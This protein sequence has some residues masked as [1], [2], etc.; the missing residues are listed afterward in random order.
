MCH[1]AHP[2]ARIPESGEPFV[3]LIRECRQ[4]PYVSQQVALLKK[5]RDTG[6]YDRA[7]IA[8]TADHGA[9]FKAGTSFRAVGKDNYHDILSIPLI[10]KLPHQSKAKIDDRAA[11]TID[12][13]PTIAAILGINL[14][15]P[16]DGQSLLGQ[17]ADPEKPRTVIDKKGRILTFDFHYRNLSEVRKRKSRLVQNQ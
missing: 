1:K 10:I 17:P 3:F 7:L 13:L 2:A 16:V 4:A 11:Q 15:F 8:V 5:L 12:I 6:L 14:P 9:S